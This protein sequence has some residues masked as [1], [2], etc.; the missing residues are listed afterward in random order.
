MRQVHAVTT[1]RIEHN[2]FVLNCLMARRGDPFA[3]LLIDTNRGEGIYPLIERRRGRSM[4]GS[5]TTALRSVR[6]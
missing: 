3:Q 2:R 4:Y 1:T 5:V 6:G